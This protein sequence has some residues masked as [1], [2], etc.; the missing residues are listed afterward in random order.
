LNVLSRWWQ[1]PGASSALFIAAI[2][3]VFAIYQ[4]RAVP[5]DR[6]RRILDGMSERFNESRTDR[7]AVLKDTPPLLALGHS[8][9]RSAV[10]SVDDE[11]G[12]VSENRVRQTVKQQ[13][14]RRL[15]QEIDD[16]DASELGISYF[17]AAEVVRSEMKFRT[18]LWAVEMVRSPTPDGLVTVET[19]K[20]VRGFI[21]RLN[22][23][24]S[25]YES[26][27]FPA[28]SM[29]GLWHVNLARLFAACAPF[30]WERSLPQPEQ[31]IAVSIQSGDGRWGRRVLY[32]GLASQHYNDVNEIH[33]TSAIVWSP[34]NNPSSTKSA[35]VHPRL[36]KEML[37]KQF[38]L[39]GLPGSPRILPYFRSWMRDQY[40]SLVGG[41][42][43]RPRGRF[44]SYGGRRLAQHM[45]AEGE[46]TTLLRFALYSAQQQPGRPF[47]L[48]FDWNLEALKRDI[49][50]ARQT[51]EARDGRSPRLTWLYIRPT[52]PQ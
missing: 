29:L 37:G 38:L 24:L 11:A 27:A 48:S 19:V 31:M 9:L 18:L 33:R 43:L 6:R 35:L 16:W 41:L 42:A 28:R 2:A 40:W 3:G 13:H 23:F 22:P 46:L 10:A 12:I 44:T 7:A 30:V 17:S 39:P 15:K 47:S 45:K 50:D 4:L 14:V 36:A 20:V 26:G 32:A 21:D 51:D 49:I 52:D 1:D 5:A 34:R 8:A 25:D